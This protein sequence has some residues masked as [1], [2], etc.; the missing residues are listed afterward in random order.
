[1]KRMFDLVL[2]LA[3]L[4]VA[5]PVF[6]IVAVAIKSASKGTVLFAQPRVG[7]N[8][9]PF[10]CYKFITMMMGVPSVGTHTA[11]AQW[12][13]PVGRFL[14]ST[15]LDELPQLLNVIRGDMSLVGPRPCLLSQTEIIEARDEEGV[16]SIRPGI[17]GLAQLAS[18]DM[19]DPPALVAADKLYLD[20]HTLWTDFIIILRTVTGA[21]RGDPIRNS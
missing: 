11:A 16:F 19:S 18:I 21:G 6:A 14:R 15:K 17:T 13:T 3:V 7:K 10:T 8:R 5:L 9:I 20:T 1:M 4:L 2:S 12:V